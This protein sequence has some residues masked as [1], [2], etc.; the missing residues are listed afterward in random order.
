MGLHVCLPWN[1]FSVHTMT[2]EDDLLLRS[3]P[4]M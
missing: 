2:Y 1:I 3:Q 4:F